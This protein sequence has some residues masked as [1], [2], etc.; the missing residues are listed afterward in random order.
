MITHRNWLA[1]VFKAFGAVQDFG[2]DIDPVSALDTYWWAP[3]AWV[4]SAHK[5]GVTLPLLSCGP[6]W[7]DR[8]PARYL[9]RPV[10]TMPL[11]ELSNGVDLAFVKLPEAKVDSC[12]ARVYDSGRLVDTW[13]QF[14]FPD[15]TLVQLQGVVDFV[16]EARFFIAYGEI[17]ASSLYR[18]RDWVWGAPEPPVDPLYEN[19]M[20]KM[21]RFARTVLDDPEVTYPPG[22]VLDIGITSDGNPKVIEA[23]AAWSSGPYDCEP[24]GVVAAIKASHDHEGQHSEW[25]WRNHTNPIWAHAGALKTIARSA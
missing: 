24:A 23:N 10:R 4:A 17:L 15:D 3:G 11:S 8:L 14:G 6:Y 9:G 12:P 16:T 20:R 13:R 2:F 19:K 1:D 22:F 7:L 21:E 5:A 25:L 18:H